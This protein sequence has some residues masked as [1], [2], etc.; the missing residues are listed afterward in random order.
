MQIFIMLTRLEP[1]ALSSPKSLEDLEKH[2]MK[3]IRNRCP[4]VNWKYNLAVLG[5]CDYLDIFEAPNV[6]TAMK[7]AAIIRSFGHGTTEIWS[8]AEWGRFKDLIRDLDS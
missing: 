3:Q 1:T 6:E 7:V 5:G 2:A 4:E 8:G